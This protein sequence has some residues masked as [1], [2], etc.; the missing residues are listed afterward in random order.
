MSRYYNEYLRDW[1]F[2]PT[3]PSLHPVSPR[4]RQRVGEVRESEGA[5][6]YHF[7]HHLLEARH[8]IADIETHCL[9]HHAILSRN[10]RRS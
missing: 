9:L 8:T 4:P 3:P 10:S 7:T 5:T 1:Y 2:A 6:L